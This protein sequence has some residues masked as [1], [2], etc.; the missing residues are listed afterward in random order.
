MPNRDPDDAQDPLSDDEDIVGI[1]DDEEDELEGFDEDDTDEEALGHAEFTAEVGSEG[2]SPGEAVE[3]ARA[4]GA[5]R[6]EQP[7]GSE[8]TETWRPAE[9]EELTIDRRDPTDRGLMKDTP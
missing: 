7:R 2:G 8:A 9:N 3:L 4:R 5:E 1:A 6:A